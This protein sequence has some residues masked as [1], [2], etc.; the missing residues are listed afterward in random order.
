MLGDQ[1]GHSLFPCLVSFSLSAQLLLLA[2]VSSPSDFLPKQNES[3][4]SLPGRVCPPARICVELG[5]FP[6]S[7]QFTVEEMERPR[8]VKP[9]MTKATQPKKQ[10]GPACL[11][12][13]LLL[14]H[15][16]D[17]WQ[18]CSGCSV[19]S[20]SFFLSSSQKGFASVSVRIG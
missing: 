10:Q 2:I 11:P 6:A 9:L 17:E 13:E 8:E 20:G 5:R 12:Q 7:K 15:M 16:S 19:H 1:D 14:L 3:F 4:S 18:S